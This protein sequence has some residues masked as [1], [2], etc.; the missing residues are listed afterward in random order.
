[1]K[2]WCRRQCL[3]LAI[4]KGKIGEE[5]GISIES[6]AVNTIAICHNVLGYMK[7]LVLRLTVWSQTIPA[8]MINNLDSA[9][10]FQDIVT[11]FWRHGLSSFP[12]LSYL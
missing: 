11:M 3:K 4:S 12:P 2:R 7:T 10:D 1:M 5:I 9:G 6:R 8:S